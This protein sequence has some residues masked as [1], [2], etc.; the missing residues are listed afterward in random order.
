MKTLD[1]YTVVVAPD[2]D[3]WW[4]HVPAIPGC[5]AMGDTA[6]EART[7]LEG[8]FE[9]FMEIYEED[10]RTLPRDVKELVAVAG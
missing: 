4:A 5:H 1:E 8:V 9:M 10:G 6:A 7:E 2:V 3:Y